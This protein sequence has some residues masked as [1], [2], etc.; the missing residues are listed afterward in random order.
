MTLNCNNSIGYSSQEIRLE[1]VSDTELIYGS[2]EKSPLDR[3][4]QRCP[5]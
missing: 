1:I 5:L 2:A 3:R 4:Y